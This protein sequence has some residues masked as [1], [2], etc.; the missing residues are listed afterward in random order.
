V[1]HFMTKEELALQEAVKK[2]PPP[3]N[4]EE[5]HLEDKMAIST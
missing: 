2:K 5:N 3:V 4:G 1:T